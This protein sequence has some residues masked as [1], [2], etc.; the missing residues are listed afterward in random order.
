MSDH[1]S[2]VAMSPAV[3][4]SPD[5]DAAE[6]KFFGQEDTHATAAISKMLVLFFFYSLLIMASV[7]YVVL[8]S[9][10]MDAP[11]KPAHDTHEA[12]APF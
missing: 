4:S 5:F 10:W 6:E 7:V 12:T 9:H 3:V 1:S 8:R 2:A 11:P